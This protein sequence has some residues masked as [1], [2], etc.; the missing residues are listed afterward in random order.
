MFE[1]HI[2]STFFCI[3]KDSPA[4]NYGFCRLF[5]IFLIGGIICLFD[6]LLIADSFIWYYLK[7]LENAHLS[8]LLAILHGWKLPVWL[9]FVQML[10]WFV[11]FEFLWKIS[12]YLAFITLDLAKLQNVVNRWFSCFL[13]LDLSTWL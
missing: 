11:C 13:Q 12:C 3:K 10:H 8:Y 2:W 1:L 7:L 5:Y 6:I 9:K 4:S